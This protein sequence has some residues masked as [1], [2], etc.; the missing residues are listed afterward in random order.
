MLKLVLRGLGGLVLIVALL[1]L[2]ALGY[3]AVRQQQTARALA[4]ATPR[5]IDEAMY[6]RIGGVEQWI[7]IRGEDRSN[8]VILNLHGGPG[9]SFDQRPQAWERDFTVVQ[10]DQRGAGHTYLRN[11]RPARG[12]T[13]ARMAQDGIE[14]AE[15]ARQRLHKRKIVLVANSWGTVLGLTMIKARPDLFCAY[16]GAGN[17]IDAVRMDGA[18]RDRLIALARARGDAK[19]LQALA[20]LGPPPWP[21]AGLDAE[22]RI[23][24]AYA[25]PADRAAIT[26]LIG[27]LLTAPGYSIGD[28]LQV[29]QGMRE[30]LE[31]LAPQVEAWKAERLGRDFQVPMLFVQGADDLVTPS[32]VVKGYADWV[33][34]PQKS[35]V[36]V[37]GAG[38]LVLV[39]RP[40][41][42]LKLMDER[43]RPLALAAER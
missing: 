15:F 20:A 28:V 2:A 23:Q 21:K 35:F 32:E 17:E 5:G 10:W 37:P 33:A 29:Q 1:A 12:L 18:A 36:L 31:R 9:L 40:E 42:V 7:S 39:S 38:H 25:P 8:P 3:R 16:V 13:I 41:L 30:S 22:R 11:P 26:S 14:A 19:S 43:I 27:G 24:S 34:A 6:V 4:V